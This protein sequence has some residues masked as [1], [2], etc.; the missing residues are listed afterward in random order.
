MKEPIP[1]GARKLLDSVQNQSFVCVGKEGDIIFGLSEPMTL[2]ALL[3]ILV[4]QTANGGLGCKAAIRLSGSITA[5][6]Y[7]DGK[8]VTGSDDVL[9][10]D[11]LTVSR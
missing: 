4:E 5:G 10:P 7:A 9:L 6:L 1:T 11:V 8:L 3:P 2:E